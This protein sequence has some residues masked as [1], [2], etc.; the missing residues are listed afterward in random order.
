[1]GADSGGS[2]ES[3][4][5]GGAP[6]TRERDALQA[7]GPLGGARLREINEILLGRNQELKATV[8]LVREKNRQVVERCAV[9]RERNA[10]LLEANATLR[11]KIASL[12][13]QLRLAVSERKL[14]RRQGR[15]APTEHNTPEG[16]DRFYADPDNLLHFEEEI[17]RELAAALRGLLVEEGVALDGRSVGDFGCGVGQVL[18]HLVEGA[19][20]AELVGLDFSEAALRA[21]RERLPTA[22]LLHHDIYDPLDRSFDV[23][24]CTETLEHLAEPRRALASVLRSL[25]PGGICLVTVPDGRSD[26]SLA[27]INFWSPESWPAFVAEVVALLAADAVE[28]RWR[29]RTLDVGHARIAYNCAILRRPG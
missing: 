22:R 10:R 2:P 16:M 7:Q 18:Q 1:M 21:A 12:A 20:P 26:V 8:A 24:L 19:S 4:V 29:C 27:H 17:Y 5:A 13:Q 14:D 15:L 11:Q 9:L 28:L 3:V 25:A 6:A 23:V